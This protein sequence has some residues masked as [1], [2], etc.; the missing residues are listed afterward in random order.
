M[1]KKELNV[2]IKTEGLHQAWNE[3][4]EKISEFIK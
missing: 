1:D 2:L 4:G 3:N